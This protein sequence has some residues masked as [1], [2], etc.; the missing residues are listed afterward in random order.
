MDKEANKIYNIEEFNYSKMKEKIEL[1]IKKLA[2]NPVK[3][4]KI[5][6]YID[7]YT[8]DGE[9]NL[10]KMRKVLYFNL[11]PDELKKNL[12]NSS[13]V[14]VNC[15]ESNDDFIRLEVSS[16]ESEE[17]V[18]SEDTNISEEVSVESMSEEEFEDA[19]NEEYF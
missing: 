9:T 7:K 6:R 19:Q 14:L 4:E 18:L 2:L 10:E 15:D 5:E 3:T 12:K 8:S 1:E 13:E 16:D 17:E 11:L